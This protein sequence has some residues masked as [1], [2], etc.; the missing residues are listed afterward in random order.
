MTENKKNDIPMFCSWDY[1]GIISIVGSIVGVILPL[2]INFGYDKVAIQAVVLAVGFSL[3][4]TFLTS[5]DDGYPS[6]C[7]YYILIIYSFSAIVLAIGYTF[8]VI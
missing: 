1:I 5:M 6:I 3:G 2:F 7:G 8:G 4:S